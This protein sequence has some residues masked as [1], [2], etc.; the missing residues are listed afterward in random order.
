[1][2]KDPISNY[3]A[4]SPTRLKFIRLGLRVQYVVFVYFNCHYSCKL[5]G[6]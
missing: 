6:K 1:M 2:G 4:R 5:F 3:A